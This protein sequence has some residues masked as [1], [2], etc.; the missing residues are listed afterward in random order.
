MIVARL[1]C[2]GKS[3]TGE[4]I[5]DAGHQMLRRGRAGCDADCSP[6]GKPIWSERVGIVNKK[7]LRAQ[8]HVVE[9][10]RGFVDPVDDIRVSNPPT[11]EA[12]LDWLAQDFSTHGYDLKHLMRT[13]VNSRTYQLS[14][15]PNEHNLADN[16]NFSRS[17]KRR[18]SAEVLL[19]AVCD[20]TG[21]RDT[22]SG[23]PPNSRAVQTWN[24]KLDSDFLDAFGRP[25]ASQECPC[26]RERKSSVVQALHLMNSNSLQNKLSSSSGKISALATSDTPEP[27]YIRPTVVAIDMRAAA[28]R[29]LAIGDRVRIIGSGLYNGET[30]LV[31]SLPDWVIPSALV[32]TEAGRTRRVRTIDLERVA[33]EA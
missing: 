29:D 10:S 25:N 18:M 32:R 2:G 4:P 14:S 16:R 7:G 6:L 15:Q 24:H 8:P 5:D 33:A 11:N 20:I 9:D 30:A 31:E 1:A 19:D 3:P 21:V 23:L 26:E 12:L 17:L 28:G 27:V 22:F 13:I